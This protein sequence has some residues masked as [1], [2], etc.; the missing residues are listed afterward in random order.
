[1]AA[2]APRAQMLW[3]RAGAGAAARRACLQASAPAADH[4]IAR[5]AAKRGG[6][7]PVV[8]WDDVP[9]ALQLAASGRCEELVSLD[10]ALCRLGEGEPRAAEV[11]RMRF[12][13]GLSGREIA[14]ALG[15]TER[16]VKRDWRYARAVL[17]R[18]LGEGGGDPEQDRE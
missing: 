7:R 9:D 15:V 14:E 8:S 3:R 6:S 16:T 18:L 11:V 17:Y 13:A 10:E 2:G 1:M 4:A 12:Y 5:N